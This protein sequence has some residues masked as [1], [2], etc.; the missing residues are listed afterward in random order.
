MSTRAGVQTQTA[1]PG[2]GAGCEVVWLGSQVCRVP[3][4]AQNFDPGGTI[5]LQDGHGLGPAGA[6]EVPHSAQNFP[7]GTC[8]PQ[9]GHDTSWG[10]AAAPGWVAP[11]HAPAAAAGAAPWGCPW[12]G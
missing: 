1:H 7:G 11:P 6:S 12:G 2:N 9:P 4:F 8:A 5:A 3:Q 10:W